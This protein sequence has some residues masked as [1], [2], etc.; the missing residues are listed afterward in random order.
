MSVHFLE[1]LSLFTK[2]LHLYV[3]VNVFDT[4]TPVALTIYDTVYIQNLAFDLLSKYDELGFRTD[5]TGVVLMLP[6]IN[7]TIEL[8]VVFESENLMPIGKKLKNLIHNAPLSR[9]VLI[10]IYVLT[11]D[12][13][14]DEYGTSAVTP[15]FFRRPTCG[16]CVIKKP[17]EC[18]SINVDF[19]SEHRW[20]TS[21]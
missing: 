6:Y 5:Y 14:L 15:S 16:I 1:W 17:I 12:A 7:F 13:L 9:Y 21:A 8:I 10:D 18:D 4:T 20:L 2:S 11:F 3:D 19:N